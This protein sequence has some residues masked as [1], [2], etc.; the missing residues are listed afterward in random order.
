MRNE[1]DNKHVVDI[2]FVIALLFLFAF[3]VLMLIALGASVYRRN[4]EIM[5]DN[6]DSRVSAAYVTEKLRQ[7]DADGGI[8]LGELGG[9]SAIL[10]RNERS[11]VPTVTYLYVHDGALYELTTLEEGGVA[12]PSAGQRITDISDMQA[13]YVREDLLSVELTRTNGKKLQLYLACRSK[14]AGETTR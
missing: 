7:A 13:G 4:V 3:S 2:L 5:S 1:R 11:G 12:V 8:T 9:E 10:L 14:D 6:N